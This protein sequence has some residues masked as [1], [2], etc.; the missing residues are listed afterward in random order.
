MA[1]ATIDAGYPLHFFGGHALQQHL[2]RRKINAAVTLTDSRQER[3][4]NMDTMSGQFRLLKDYFRR[5]RGT[6]RQQQEIGAD[7]IAYA[8]TDYWFDTLPVVKS[9]AKRKLMVLGMDAP[10]LRQIVTRAR[11]DVTAS[12]INSIYYWCS[13]NL[14]LRLFQ[15]CS[16][17]RLFYVHPSM[18][19]RL[20]K[21][22]YSKQEIVFISN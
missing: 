11:P 7:D 2:E 19:A 13:Q 9:R 8:V 15:R 4:I 10:T 18:E 16:N 20:L 6:L 14:S 5:L 21:M 22:G 1:Q 12:R 17:K 3:G